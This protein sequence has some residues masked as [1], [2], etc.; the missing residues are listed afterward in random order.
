MFLTTEFSTLIHQPSGP[1]AGSWPRTN[2]SWT[3]WLRIDSSWSSWEP[4]DPRSTDPGAADP[5]PVHLEQADCKLAEDQL[6]VDLV[7]LN[8]QNMDQRRTGWYLFQ[9]ASYDVQDYFQG[10]KRRPR[11]PPGSSWVSA[12][13]WWKLR[14]QSWRAVAV[15]NKTVLKD[16]PLYPWP[17]PIKWH[18]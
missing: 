9:I 15:V 6:I 7:I 17:V 2:W 10:G 16:F 5:R 8:Q 13:T 12:T 3:N 11:L 4:A 18:S 14:R 1:P